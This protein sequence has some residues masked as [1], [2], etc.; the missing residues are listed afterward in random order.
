[1]TNIKSKETQTSLFFIFLIFICSLFLFRFYVY[2]G[3]PIFRD[4]P[5]Q[6]SYFC[7]IAENWFQYGLWNSPHEATMGG[8]PLNEHQ[9]SLGY[10]IG[11]FINLLGFSLTAS[12][13]GM[14][15][16]IAFL[17]PF[18]FYS[19][20]RV[21]VKPLYAF[22]GSFLLLFYIEW[23]YFYA[24]GFFHQYFAVSISLFFIRTL[25]L[26]K[27]VINSVFASI[28]LALVIWAHLYIG[29]FNV[30][31]LFVYGHVLG[32]EIGR[33]K[34]FLWLCLVLGMSFALCI[35]YGIRIMQSFEWLENTQNIQLSLK[36]GFQYGAKQLFGFSQYSNG[37]FLMRCLRFLLIGIGAIYG[38]K[39]WTAK[40][41]SSSWQSF[42][43]IIVLASMLISIGLITKIFSFFQVPILSNIIIH[44]F[45]FMIYGEIGVII[46]CVWAIKV[47]IDNI[48]KKVDLE[49]KFALIMIMLSSLAI[50]QIPFSWLLTEKNRATDPVKKLSEWIQ[51][52]KI[53]DRERI[54]FQ[55]TM[56]NVQGPL[57]QSHLLCPLWTQTKVNQLGAWMGGSLFPIQ[58]HIL[59]ESGQIFGQ[60]PETVNLEYIRDFS[61]AWNISYMVFCESES[62]KWANKI[63]WL[64]KI[65]NIGP[66]HIYD[67]GFGNEK[68]M[69]VTNGIINKSIWKDPKKIELEFSLYEKG[70]LHFASAFHPNWK[71][72]LNGETV[73]LQ[74]D[75]YE[76]IASA[77][78]SP[79]KYEGMLIYK[80][81]S[82]FMSYM[83]S[84]CL[85]L[86]FIV[87]SILIW[88]KDESLNSRCS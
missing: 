69:N 2:Q 30:F 34:S 74:A 15:F 55:S 45:R 54:Y 23:I 12:Y 67:T 37:F 65:K 25:F 13:K 72:I 32:K 56:N 18:S 26:N 68:V 19:L 4:H 84:L 62:I 33:K 78:L 40:E 5:A 31:I 73:S 64:E 38:I 43:I 76:R 1:M 82:G 53:S 39:K 80:N 44:G 22:L 17:F 27:S 47:G 3:I 58:K 86:I 66:F 85:Y 83:I 24:S 75:D 35:P 71:L 42:W 77:L 50:H 70:V 48:G 87:L 6:F 60:K 52:E 81:S 16:I 59:S 7:Q 88:R 20:L 36:E 9:Y 21:K 49:I 14:L 57:G 79:G 8:M 61:K 28:L 46:F 10:I 29:L 63:G 51:N 11:L 41:K